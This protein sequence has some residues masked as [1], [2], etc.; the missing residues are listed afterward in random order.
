MEL[1]IEKGF[2]DQGI[3]VVR[4]V[5]DTIQQCNLRCKYCHPG[6]VWKQTHLK[7]SAVEGVLRAA[8]AN[9][10]L[11]VTL[12]GGEITLHPELAQILEATHLLKR[13][14]ATFITNATKI[15][16]ELAERI[17]ESN[18]G[19]ICVSIDGADEETHNSARGNNFRKV[20]QGLDALRKAEKDITIISVA[21]HKNYKRLLELSHMLANAGLAT[22]H[23][24]CAPSYSG[25]AKK[26]YQEFR[27]RD[28]EFEELQ[29]TLD[30]HFEDLRKKGLYVTFNSYWPAIGKRSK[31][32]VSREITLVQLTE[33]LKD[34][35]LI[36]RAD[37]DVRLTSAAWGRETIGDAVI[38]NLNR[39]E[40]DSLFR[41]VDAIY[42]DGAV[43]QL[44]REIEATHKFHVGANA[45]KATTD[46][47]LEH[48]DDAPSVLPMIPITPLSGS[49]ILEREISLNELH[50]LAARIAAA[51]DRYRIILNPSGVYVLFDRK[52]TH[53]TFLKESEIRQIDSFLNSA[54]A[55]AG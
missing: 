11:E 54:V 14:V 8:E 13:T 38:G 10:L 34:C 36:V 17:K 32:D 24:L 22:Q 50:D 51:E 2:D 19:R 15:T 21:H 23:H 29:Q 39:E 9:S 47:L 55:L 42:R 52:S 48:R 3:Q 5:V 6:E 43:R 40:A 12:S 37:G 31:V 27:L 4:A 49:D 45:D 25:E 7:A 46:W 1:K 18:V 44:P 53:V 20:M 35:Y 16:P 26:Y 28:E 30:G 41:K 33:Q